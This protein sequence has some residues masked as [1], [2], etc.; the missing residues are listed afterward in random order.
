M[1]FGFVIFQRARLLTNH[2]IINFKNIYYHCRNYIADV[3]KIVLHLGSNKSDRVSYIQKA[4]ALIQKH[5]C[6]VLQ[7]S[8]LYE[9]EPWGLADQE[10]FINQTI[11]VESNLSAEQLIIKTKAIE[12]EIGREKTEKWGPRN[13]DID[14]LLYGNKKVEKKDLIIPHPKITE[15]NFVLIPL[16]ELLPDLILPGFEYSVEELYEQCQDSCEVRIYEE[17]N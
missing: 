14:I 9:T 11:I 15:R 3:E 6:K 16:M 8:M 1:P 17:E 10:D 2:C 12:E 13:I 5:I 4:I 7:K